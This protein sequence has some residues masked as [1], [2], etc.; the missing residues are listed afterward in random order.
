MKSMSVDFYYD[1]NGAA[2]NAANAI[3]ILRNDNSARHS[4]ADLWNPNP[5]PAWALLNAPAGDAFLMMGTTEDLSAALLAAK[6]QGAMYIQI[7]GDHMALWYLR[8]KSGTFTKTV[9]SVAPLRRYWGLNANDPTQI[10]G[11]YGNWY[12]LWDYVYYDT[13][14]DIAELA[15]NALYRAQGV[16]AWY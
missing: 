12:P 6:S 4:F 3:A 8:R 10:H 15:S 9:V 5:V 13:A 14:V 2:K 16:E 7:P 11:Q 1:N